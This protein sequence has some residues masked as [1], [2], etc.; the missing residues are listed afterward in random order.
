[1]YGWECGLAVN[2]VSTKGKRVGENATGA[3]LYVNVVNRCNGKKK[4]LQSRRQYIFYIFYEES[5]N[6]WSLNHYSTDA[7]VCKKTSR[8]G[9]E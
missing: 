5:I 8:W 3:K 6:L 7:I 9:C 4:T 2:A 1:L